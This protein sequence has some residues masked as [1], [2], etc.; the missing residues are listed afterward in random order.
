MGDSQFV[1]KIKMAC[2]SLGIESSVWLN[3]GRK[4]APAILN[5][6][7]ASELNKRALGNWSTDGF[8]EVYSSKLLIAAIRV[9]EGF[10]KRSGMHHN[11]RTTFM[12]MT[13]IRF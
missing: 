4:K 11:P 2:K 10:D 8:G 9:M 1:N 5:L 6:E 13:N 3:F 12:V 7:E